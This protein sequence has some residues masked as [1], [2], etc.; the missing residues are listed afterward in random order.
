MT[1]EEM[2]DEEIAAEIS[3]LSGFVEGVE[4]GGDGPFD[5]WWGPIF[6]SLP[7]R[8]REKISAHDW[9]ETGKEY[10][11]AIRQAVAEEREQCAALCQIAKDEILAETPKETA[12]HIAEA[13]IKT[14][15]AIEAGIRARNNSAVASAKAKG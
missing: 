3:S 5:L 9:R 15:E 4:K 11:K 10:K 7:L 6:K 12:C 2:T 14:A 13:M 8:A 1:P